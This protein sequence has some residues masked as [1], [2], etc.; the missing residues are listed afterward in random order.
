MKEVIE[1][2]LKFQRE[3][4]IERTALFQ[5]LAT[6]QTRAPCLS[7]VPTAAWCRSWSPSASRA[8]CS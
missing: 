2:F 5:Q 4:F 6:R 3:A 7:H 1:G 8:I